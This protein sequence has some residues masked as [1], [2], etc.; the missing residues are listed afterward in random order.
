MPGSLTVLVL[1][2][3]PETQE[4]WV[5]ARLHSVLRRELGAFSPTAET[6]LRLWEEAQVAGEGPILLHIQGRLS[7]G[8]EFSFLF[9]K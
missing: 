6:A 2:H 7:G 5:P 9:S 8:A 4:I 1:H 3:T